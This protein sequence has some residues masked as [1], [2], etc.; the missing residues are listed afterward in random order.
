MFH[1]H[2]GVSH[3]HNIPLLSVNSVSLPPLKVRL[4]ADLALRK[5]E[6]ATT[7]NGRLPP[8]LEPAMFLLVLPARDAS[9]IFISMGDSHMNI[10]L[11]KSMPSL[12]S[13]DCILENCC[14]CAMIKA[15]ILA[16]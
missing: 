2:H 11:T 1:Q 6:G 4:M 16:Y 7:D 3:D 13:V 10:G 15:L 9:S 12:S 8:A 5:E 14:C